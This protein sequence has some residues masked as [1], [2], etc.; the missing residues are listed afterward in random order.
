MLTAFLLTTC[1][2]SQCQASCDSQQR[3]KPAEPL[4]PGVSGEVPLPEP[5]Q[6]SWA[7]TLC[8]RSPVARGLSLCACVCV[9]LCV[10]TGVGGSGGIRKALLAA[11]NL[12]GVDRRPVGHTPLPRRGPAPERTGQVGFPLAPSDGAPG[13]VWRKRI[14]SVFVGEPCGLSRVPG[15]KQPTCLCFLLHVPGCAWNRLS[16]LWEAAGSTG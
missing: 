10:W 14:E 7:I 4:G 5:L 15:L 16:Y 13:G 1:G 8:S 9:C 12:T 2:Q 6:K 3:G 11:L